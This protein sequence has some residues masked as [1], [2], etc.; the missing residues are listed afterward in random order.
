MSDE[1]AFSTAIDPLLQ[2][3]T[4]NPNAQWASADELTKSF[5]DGAVISAIVSGPAHINKLDASD[6]G[7][8]AE[9]QMYRNS[10]DATDTEIA[11]IDAGI[12][13]ILTGEENVDN[14]EVESN[15]YVDPNP[16]VEQIL[17]DSTITKNTDKLL[18]AMSSVKGYDNA[19]QIFNQMNL[20]NVRTYPNGTI[21]GDLSDGRV[22]NV[23]PSSKFEYPTIEIHDPKTGKSIKIRF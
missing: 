21:A 10:G 4:Y 9:L 11:E 18:N 7:K 8:I 3:M 20:E 16:Q 19:V 1:E 13:E 14:V 15:E 6:L 2:K 12:N 5:V 17:K 23:R 22:V